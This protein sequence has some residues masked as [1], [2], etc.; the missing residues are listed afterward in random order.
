MVFTKSNWCKKAFFRVLIPWF[1]GLGF[2]L[3]DYMKGVDLKVL[4]PW[5]SGL[6]FHHK[7]LDGATI[8]LSLNPLVFGA[9]FSP[10]SGDVYSVKLAS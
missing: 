8:A 3:G 2:H 4:I 1:S 7:T 5:F 9:W 6:G 10:D